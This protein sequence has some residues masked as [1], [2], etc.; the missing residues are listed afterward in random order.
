MFTPVT[1]RK[2]QINVTS[3]Q[4]RHHLNG[5]GRVCRTSCRF[6]RQLV[7]ISAFVLYRCPSPFL[8]CRPALAVSCHFLFFLNTSSPSYTATTG[9]N[10]HIMMSCMMLEG[11]QSWPGGGVFTRHQSSI[12][13]LRSPGV[14]NR[15]NSLSL[16]T[17]GTRSQTEGVEL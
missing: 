11:R 5:D 13:C 6:R 1:I 3:L 15:A 7:F 8:V 17:V 14:S 4:C 10:Q 12:P 9:Q 2:C 16:S